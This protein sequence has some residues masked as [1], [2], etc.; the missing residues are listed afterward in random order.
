MLIKHYGYNLDTWFS[1]KDLSS[2]CQ[3]ST[4]RAARSIYLITLFPPRPLYGTSYSRFPGPA[5]VTK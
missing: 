4:A 3:S 2:I 5:F 1:A